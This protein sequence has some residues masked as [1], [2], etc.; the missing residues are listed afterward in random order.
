MLTI[1][2]VNAAVFPVPPECDYSRTAISG[3][4]GRAGI[5]AYAAR[6][7]PHLSGCTCEELPHRLL[8]ALVPG[9]VKVVAAFDF[10]QAAVSDCHG[11]GASRADHAIVA[12]NRQ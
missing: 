5:G 2:Q 3:R 7:G 4:R 11:K 6:R 10:H 8:V 12:S 1:V 9:S